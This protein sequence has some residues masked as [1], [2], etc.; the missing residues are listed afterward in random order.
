MFALSHCVPFTYPALKAAF[1]GTHINRVPAPE[2]GV[3]PVAPVTSKPPSST[4]SIERGLV[5]PIP[6]LPLFL[7][8]NLS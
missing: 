8:V 3:A 6:T 1:S 5:V 2:T 7:I 4:C